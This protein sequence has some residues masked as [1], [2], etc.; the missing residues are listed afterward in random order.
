MRTWMGWVGVGWGGR[1]CAWMWASTGLSRR[2]NL[3]LVVL[4]RPRLRQVVFPVV[5]RVVH[6]APARARA[7]AAVKAPTVQT[8]QTLLLHKRSNQGVT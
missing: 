1:W 4:E 3:L 7:H 5:Q 8:Q 6:R 2:A